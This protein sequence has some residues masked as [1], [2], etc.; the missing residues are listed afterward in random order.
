LTDALSQWYYQL[1]IQLIKPPAFYMKIDFTDR[2]LDVMAVLWDRGSGTVSEVRHAL[3]G[4]F[5]YNTVLTVLRTLEDKGYVTHV[6]EGRAHRYVSAVEPDV[7]GKSA[8]TRI[9]QKMFSGSRELLL[10]QLL[11]DRNITRDQLKQLHA[12]L[13]ARLAAQ[14]PDKNG[15]RK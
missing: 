6:A 13:G 7:A 11:S 12:V 15:N 10:M 1:T 2:E 5:A 14:T 8:L 3:Q 9:L 4:S